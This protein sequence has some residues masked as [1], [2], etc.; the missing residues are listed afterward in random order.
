MNEVPVRVRGIPLFAKNTK[1]GASGQILI[2]GS[3]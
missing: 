1:D 3:N 2:L